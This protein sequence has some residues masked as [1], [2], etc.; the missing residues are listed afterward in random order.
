MVRPALR[1]FGVLVA[2]LTGRRTCANKPLTFYSF[3][4]TRSG[5]EPRPPAPRA[6]ALTTVLH[7]GGP[8]WVGS[9]IRLISPV[10]AKASS[11]SD[12]RIMMV[13]GL[14]HW[15]LSGLILEALQLE[16]LEFLPVEETD[17]VTGTG[18][19]VMG[20]SVAAADLTSPK[21]AGGLKRLP[22][23][24][25]LKAFQHSSFSISCTGMLCRYPGSISCSYV[26]LVPFTCPSSW[27]SSSIPRGLFLEAF[28]HIWMARSR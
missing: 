3:G 23:Y 5:I 7:R 21:G 25:F 4:V 17:T 19:T 24:P 10:P 27:S 8:Q 20:A 22:H 15:V 16:L 1:N 6:D 28:F 9:C 12:V 11:A 18:S 2:K 26:F 14:W 13:R